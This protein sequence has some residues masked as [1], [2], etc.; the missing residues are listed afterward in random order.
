MCLSRSASEQMLLARETERKAAVQNP[1]TTPHVAATPSQ[2]SIGSSITQRSGDSKRRER[3]SLA[4]L[5]FDDAEEVRDRCL[6]PQRVVAGR[7]RTR[8]P[9]LAPRAPPPSPSEAGG[10]QFVHA[11]A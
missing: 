10:Q 7:A 6:V 2:H 3:E 1:A 5:L 8:S 9:L 4:D 11:V